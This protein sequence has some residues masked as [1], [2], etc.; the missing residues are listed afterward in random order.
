LP[1][2]RAECGLHDAQL[3]QLTESLK[4]QGTPQP[5]LLKS[6]GDRFALIASE[7]C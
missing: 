4:A 7:R 6:L 2:A 5:A 1:Q 3:Q